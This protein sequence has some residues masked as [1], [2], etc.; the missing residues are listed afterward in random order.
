M[1][2]RILTTEALAVLMG[3]QPYTKTFLQEFCNCDNQEFLN[4]V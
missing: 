4:S 3:R 2:S 1:P